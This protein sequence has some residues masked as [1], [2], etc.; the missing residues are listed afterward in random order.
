MDYI[1][2]ILW[3]CANMPKRVKE[4]AGFWTGVDGVLLIKSFDLVDD[5]HD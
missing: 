5:S 1:F 4:N 2:T 3:Y